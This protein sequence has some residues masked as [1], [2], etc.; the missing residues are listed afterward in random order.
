MLMG[1]N[2]GDFHSPAST[3]WCL[4]AFIVDSNNNYEDFYEFH[5]YHSVPLQIVR[6]V[7]IIFIYFFFVNFILAILTTMF[8]LALQV[9]REPQSTLP[10]CNF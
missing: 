4:I 6:W 3:I 10:H 8:H 5:A 1:Y 2:N 9:S 7:M